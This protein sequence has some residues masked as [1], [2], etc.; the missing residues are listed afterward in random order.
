MSVLAVLPPCLS[1]LSLGLGHSQVH[2]LG[3]RATAQPI[4]PSQSATQG[5]C[6]MMPRTAPLP[7]SSLPRTTPFRAALMAGERYG[8]LLCLG[9]AHPDTE[10]TQNIIHTG[11]WL[12]I[13][14]GTHKV[15]MG[16]L[17]APGGPPSTPT[18]PPSPPGSPVRTRAQSG[19]LSSPTPPQ[20]CPK[21]S[22][23]SLI[24]WPSLAKGLRGT[25]SGTHN[26]SLFVTFL[27]IMTE[28]LIETT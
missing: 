1:W 24:S 10:G 13:Q 20:F 27:V 9:Q 19:S 5:T 28:W 23:K 2:T 25:S 22:L 12:L 7:D 26:I 17:Q 21:I 3:S 14:A 6:P 16:L 18:F 8:T 15:C 4:C 11:N